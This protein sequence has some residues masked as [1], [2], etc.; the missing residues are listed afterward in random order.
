MVGCG[1][2]W[3]A[4]R[5]WMGHRTAWI[6]GCFTPTLYQRSLISAKLVFSLSILFSLVLPFTLF[7]LD[8]TKLSYRMAITST[9]RH[10]DIVNVREDVGS[11]PS[12][13]LL[14]VLLTVKVSHLQINVWILNVNSIKC[15]VLFNGRSA[16]GKWQKGCCCRMLSGTQSWFHTDVF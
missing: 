6:T 16:G 14:F 13:F 3:V 9:G 10:G 5:K 1:S 4:R 7:C 15:E 8:G 12:F 11:L 2:E